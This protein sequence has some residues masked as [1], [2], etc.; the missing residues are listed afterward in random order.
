MLANRGHVGKDVSKWGHV[1]KR[2]EGRE[3]VLGR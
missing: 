2:S 1:G 3:T